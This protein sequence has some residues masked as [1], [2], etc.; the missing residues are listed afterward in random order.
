MR[1]FLFSGTDGITAL[2][3]LLNQHRFDTPARSVRTSTM[4]TLA[5]ST[6]RIEFDIGRMTENVESQ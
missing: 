1:L 6:R 3:S 4:K 5:N 2:L